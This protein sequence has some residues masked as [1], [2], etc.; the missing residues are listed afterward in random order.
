MTKNL[1]QLRQVAKRATPGPWV[2][3]DRGIGY[4]VHD[5]YGYELN[6]GM[7]ETFTEADATHIATFDPPTALAL[8]DR[9]EAAEQA[10]DFHAQRDSELKTLL[11]MIADRLDEFC[12]DELS[13]LIEDGPLDQ[14]GETYKS[15]LQ[16]AEQA[17]ERAKAVDALQR[18]DKGAL[19]RRAEVA[20]GRLSAVGLV[21]DDLHATG[22]ISQDVA[23]QLTDALEGKNTP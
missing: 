7:R 3:Y 16:T 11:S 2:V 14:W 19:Y 9:A 21:V 1:D 12:Y 4:E 18:R 20:E 23:D 15:K 13:S 22:A 8:I 17:V 5:A 10:V 6:G